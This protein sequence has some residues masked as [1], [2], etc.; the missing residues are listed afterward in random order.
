MGTC[1]PSPSPSAGITADGS[2]LEFSSY[3]GGSGR[4]EAHD[5]AVDGLGNAYVT[6]FTNSPDFPVRNA[7]QLGS[8][9]LIAA[10]V[11]ER[12]DAEQDGEFAV[13]VQLAAESA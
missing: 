11:I 6:G 1:L 9:D 10:G 7:L 8:G 3:L 2:A 12:L 13:E 4:D 5:V